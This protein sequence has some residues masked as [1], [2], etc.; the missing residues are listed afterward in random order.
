MWGDSEDEEL[1]EQQEAE[2]EGEQDGDDDDGDE[3]GDEDD[4]SSSVASVELPGVSDD[5]ILD[6]V[7][8]WILT[9]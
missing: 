7:R 3:E 8:C 5:D 4:G 2:Q 1:D 9:I 6:G